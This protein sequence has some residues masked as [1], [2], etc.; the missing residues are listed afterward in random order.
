MG[1]LVWYVLNLYLPKPISNYRLLVSIWVIW[2]CA[3]VAVYKIPDQ[4]FTNRQIKDILC[5]PV[6]G[7]KLVLLVVGRLA[8]SQFGITISAFWSYFLYDCTDWALT[9]I[10]ILFSLVSSWVVDLLV[11]IASTT[12]GNMLSVFCVGYGF[13]IFQ[14]GAFLLLTLS[15]GGLAS[16]IL[17][18]PGFLA[19][20]NT[21][22]APN[23]WLLIAMLAA[24]LSACCSYFCVRDGYIRSYLNTQN[25]QGRK[26][27]K[28]IAPTKIKNPYLLL[29]WKRVLRNK[30]LIF[31]SNIK[32]I[33][34]VLVL[35]NLL[36]QNLGWKG[37]PEK[38]ALELFLLVSCC[39]VNTI[40]STAYSSDPNRAYVSFL[41]ISTH[42]LFLW[43]TLQGFAWGEITVLLFWLGVTL[44]RA[45][46]MT[47]ACMLLLYGT[48]MNYGCSWL[49]VFLDYKMPRTPT[50]TNEL[51]HGNIS[52]VIVLFASIAL[53]I[54]E[55][56]FTRQI[57]RFISLLSFAVCVSV[58]A[59]MV[60]FGYWL[61]CRR[62]FHD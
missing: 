7:R 43:K 9:V 23:W 45:I 52:K 15:A 3:F 6:S 41:P 36:L 14:Y 22:F 16:R 17:F 20:M 10:V 62:A 25:F 33:L 38:Y 24:L 35:C 27:N 5:F 8:C 48:A 61:L 32:N 4:L 11:L 49:G 18:W 56:Y 40:S 30:E 46:P 50:S 44:V 28:R 55:I 19:Q 2:I 51:L 39:G 37:L 53:T 57:A 31:F 21:I 47:N 42:R 34:T 1:Y 26:T 60:E 58:C 13:I 54:W 29:E 59:V 12:I